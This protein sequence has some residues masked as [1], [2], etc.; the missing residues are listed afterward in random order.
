MGYVKRK[1]STSDK[2]PLVQFE[3]LK[4]IFLADLTVEVVMNENSKE[5]I[6]N[7][8]QTG[9]S[10][11]PTGD[12]TMEKEGVSR[13]SIANADDKRQLTAV[14]AVTAAGEYF[15]PQLLYKGKITKCHP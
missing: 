11:I 2:I 10:I 6:L 9:V 3:E 1:C 8:D 7:W 5:L 15:A 12:W 4:E 14:L 13:V